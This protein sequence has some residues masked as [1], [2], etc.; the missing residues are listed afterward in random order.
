MLKPKKR[1]AKKEIKEDTLLKAYARATA[2]Y[3]ENKKYVT[4]AVTGLVVIIAAVIIVINNR[5]ANNE[6]ATLELAKVFSIYDAGANDLQQYK[7]AINGQPERGV[8]GLKGIVANYGSSESGELAR[9][10]LANAYYNLGQYD[11]A[12][13]Q[14]ESFSGGTTFLKAAADFGIGGCH[15]ARRDY[16]RAASFYEKAAGISGAGSM[17]P[18]YLNAAARC[19]GLSGEKEKAVVI[20][21]R[22]KK[23]FPTSSVARDADRFISQFSV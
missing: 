21:K 17:T 2:F 14:Y 23:E 6:K 16:A 13:Q 18:E 15:E 1:L 3:Y 20:Y 9:F 4:Y 19:F 5:R 10:Y 11:D 22:I 8:M 12:L 7:V